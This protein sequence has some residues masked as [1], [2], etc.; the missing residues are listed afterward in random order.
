MD[1]HQILLI[2][3]KKSMKRWGKEGLILLHAWTQRNHSQ[4]QKILD[5]FIF[6][7][8][9]GDISHRKFQRRFFSKNIYFF[10]TPGLKLSICFF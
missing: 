7:L 9:E 3:N 4:K 5:K 8:L 10:K 1:T 6:G 2:K